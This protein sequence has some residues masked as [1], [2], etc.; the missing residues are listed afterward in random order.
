M[1]A[2]PFGTHARRAGPRRAARSRVAR[3]AFGIVAITAL[4]ACGRESAPLWPG[5]DVRPLAQASPS[6]GERL[7][8]THGCVS[9][10]AIPGVRGPS[11]GVGPP[12]A[13]MGSRAYI[14]GVLP[15]TPENLVRWLQDPPAIDARTVMP[16]VGLSHAEA[17][18]IAAYLLTLR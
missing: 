6:R 5:P 3:L 18:D 17:V 14:G 1:P 7:I 2:C 10:H 11:S 16:N 8:A 12:L 9:C 15:N 4:P 13:A